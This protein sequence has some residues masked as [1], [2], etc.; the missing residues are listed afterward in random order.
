MS[1]DTPSGCCRNSHCITNP[2][3][4]RHDGV[5]LSGS[6]AAEHD[7]DA[8]AMDD[9]GAIMHE[10]RITLDRER[11]LWQLWLPNVAGPAYEHSDLIV[12]E[13]LLDQLQNQ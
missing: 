7:A 2:T 1:G 10:A 13:R 3:G 4:P 5:A 8:A 9:G 11:N 6:A 12:L